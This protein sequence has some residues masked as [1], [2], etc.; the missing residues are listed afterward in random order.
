MTTFALGAGFLVWILQTMEAWS[1]KNVSI[2]GGVLMI[3][4]A[5][6]IQVGF[7]QHRD[8]GANYILECEIQLI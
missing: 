8:C 6:H 4:R 7:A 5:L 2:T 3:V 1:E